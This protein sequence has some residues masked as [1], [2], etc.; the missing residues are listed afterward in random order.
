MKSFKVKVNK[1]AEEDLRRYTKYVKETLGNSQ[2]AKSIL[3]DFR[4]TKRKLT[5]IAESIVKPENDR[6][7]EKSLKRINFKK[8]NYFLLF[9]I[10]DDIVY[11]TNMFHGSE[12][13]EAKLR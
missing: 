9:K 13:Y 8:H 2:A 6:L 12:D 5:T 1:E 7:K 3:V 10:V 11:I 4:E